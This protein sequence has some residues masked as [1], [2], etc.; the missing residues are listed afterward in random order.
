MAAPN[1]SRGTISPAGT[2]LSVS[3]VRGMDGRGS[4]RV[5]RRE[6]A[7]RGRTQSPRGQRQASE[8][9]RADQSARAIP[10]DQMG[11]SRPRVVEDQAGIGPL[12]EPRKAGGEYREAGEHVPDTEDAHEVRR[13]TQVAND[14]KEGLHS[15]AAHHAADHALDGENHG[16]EPVCDG[17]PATHNG[18]QADDPA[19]MRWSLELTEKELARVPPP[20]RKTRIRGYAAVHS[21]VLSV[22]RPIVQLRWT[23]DRPI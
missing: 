13:V 11:D 20:H 21:D 8:N 5:R 1:G 10:H 2:N 15:K 14:P 16:R 9:D 7:T 12:L 18:R 22:K 23:G 17:L 3:V 4:R 19:H 6:V